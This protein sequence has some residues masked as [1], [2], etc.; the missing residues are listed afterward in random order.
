MQG[1]TPMAHSI[2]KQTIDVGRDGAGEKE[3]EEKK[4]K[5]LSFHDFP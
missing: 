3:V 1:K 5:T 2:I 4:K